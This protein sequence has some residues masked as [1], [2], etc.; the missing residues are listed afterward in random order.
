MQIL[1]YKV[2]DV[3]EL[4][5]AH[6]CN[7]RSKTFKIMALGADVKI[8]CLGCGAVILL[9]RYEFNRRLKIIL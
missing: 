5:K 1:D 2:G 4:K 6:P 9:P 3:V 8:K 7:E